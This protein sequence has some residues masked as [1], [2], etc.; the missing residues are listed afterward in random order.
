[1]M[2]V[3]ATDIVNNVVRLDSWQKQNVMSKK[4]TGAIMV[5]SGHF[6]SWGIDLQKDFFP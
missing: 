6:F 1:M 5:K 2:A 3:N 4:D